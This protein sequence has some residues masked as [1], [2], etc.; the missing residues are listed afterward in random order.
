MRSKIL[1][2]LPAC[3]LTVAVALASGYPTEPPGAPGPPGPPET[4]GQ[5]S[6]PGQPGQPGPPS[7][8]G[9]SGRVNSV[10]VTLP[11]DAAPPALQV[12]RTFELNNRYMDRATSSYQ[13]SFG[14]ALTNEPLNRVDRNFNLVPAAA[15]HWEVTDDGHTW[16]FHLRKDMVFG[17]GKPVTAYDYEDTFRR[18]ADPDI[19]FDFEWYYRPIRNWGAVVARKMPLDSL[20]VEALDPHTLAFTTT[21]PAPF[22]PLLLNYSWVTP[23]HQFEKYG[24]AW[25]TKA[26]THIGSGPYRLKEWTINDRIVLEPSPTYP[27]PSTPYL[28]RIIARLYNAAAQ[29]PFLASY[30]A[31]EVDYVPLNNPAEINR[32]RSD[33]VLR[34]HLNTYTNFTTYYLFMDTRVPPFNDLRVRQAISHAIDQPAIMKSALKDIAVPAVSLMPAGFPAANTEALA[35]IQRYD[36]ERARR[37]LAEAGYPDGRGFPVMDMWLRGEAYL[38]KVAAEAIQAMLKQNLNIDVEV[39]NVERKV[40]TEA[41][42]A[43]EIP[44]SMIAYGWDYLDPSNLLNLFLSRGRHPWRNDQYEEIIEQANQLVGDPDRRTRL[45]QQAEEILVREVG[46]VFLWHDLVN[47]MWRPY[48]RGDALEPNESGYRAWRGNQMLNLMTTIYITE[49]VTREKAARKP[50]GP[51]SWLT[52]R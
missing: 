40:Y 29:P 52:G 44:L 19:G 26:E 48:I 42:N 41:M 6:Q 9:P 25:S 46:G 39:L 13:K 14:F 20:G 4:P 1:L 24:A 38:R 34:S 3:I 23:T 47:E 15:T 5:P 33:P 51:W 16:V 2:V 45:Y 21:R 22:A 50:G 43:K 18:W 11:P 7:A 8:Q 28:E 30:E 17:D 37:L 12:L 49:D 10:G 27:G 36:P 31:N 35:H 32:A